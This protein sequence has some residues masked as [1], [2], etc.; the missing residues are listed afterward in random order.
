MDTNSILEALRSPEGQ[1]LIQAEVR[2]QVQ[3]A[4]PPQKSLGEIA[5]AVHRYV[6]AMTKAEEDAGI[7]VYITGS[8]LRSELN[9]S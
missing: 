8:K 5:D 4:I 9:E 6:K 7:Q 3:A 2:R 1:A